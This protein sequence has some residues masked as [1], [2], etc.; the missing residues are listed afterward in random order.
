M[1]LSCALKNGADYFITCDD[2]IITKRDI[3][4]IDLTII[5]PVG[6]VLGMETIKHENNE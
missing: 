1:H 4:G 6:F 3:L 5:N 2:K